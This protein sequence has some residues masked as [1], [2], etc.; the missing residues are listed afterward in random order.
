MR[1]ASTTTVALG[2]AEAADRSTPVEGAA[3]AVPAR[4]VAAV[5]TATATATVRMCGLRNLIRV[6]PF[7]G[8][9]SAQPPCDVARLGVTGAG[10]APRDNPC[11]SVMGT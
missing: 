11:G 9:R 4:P 7:E 3:K 5:V 1:A 8:G 2:A 6:P 10:P